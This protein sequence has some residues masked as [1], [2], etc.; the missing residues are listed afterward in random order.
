LA[1]NAAAGAVI[2]ALG[3][4]ITGGI[5]IGEG[6]RLRPTAIS[7]GI[8]TAAL[9]GGATLV[10]DLGPDPVVARDPSQLACRAN[11]KL[12]VCV[13]P[14]HGT[15][16]NEVAEIATQAVDGWRAE[17][18]SVPTIFTEAVSPQLR[19][20]E[21]SFGFSLRASHSDIQ[22]ALAYGLLPPWPACADVGSFPGI[23][24]QVYVHAW[25]DATAGM[26][27]DEL[28]QRFSASSRPGEPTA[29]EAVQALRDAS[30]EVRTKWLTANLAVLERCDLEP[31]PLPS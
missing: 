31:Q 8:I 2:V 9:L 18:I 7:L 1:P 25:L 6:W 28:S 12:M 16:L 5:L 13:W 4:L 3:L 22:H 30:P 10:A 21:A 26:A 17:G 14:E 29:L 27:T 20:G 24:A 15:R 19:R 11:A 23:D